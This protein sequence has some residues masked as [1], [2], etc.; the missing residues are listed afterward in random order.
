MKYEAGLFA[1]NGNSVFGFADTEVGAIDRALE[2][3]RPIRATDPFQVI[4]AMY[5]RCGVDCDLAY[6]TTLGAFRLDIE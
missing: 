5:R 4:L 2:D 1:G 3:S 6:A